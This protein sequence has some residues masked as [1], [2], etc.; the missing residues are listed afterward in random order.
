MAKRTKISTETLVKLGAPKLAALILDETAHNRRFKQFAQLALEAQDGPTS[1]ATALKRRFSTIARS[2]T[3]LAKEKKREQLSELNKLKSIA[4]NEIAEIDAKLALELLWEFL[5]LHQ[6]VLERIDDSSGRFGTM[7]R[8]A[9]LNLGPLAEAAKGDPDL[10][11][12][13]IF[14]KLMDN[15]YGIYD[16]LVAVLSEALGP[17]G[18]S[19]LRQA[20]LQHQNELTQ[21]EKH[22][23]SSHRYRDNELSAIKLALRE[24]ADCE[25]DPDAFIAT[26]DDSN[27]SNPRF[28]SEVAHRLLAAG[29]AEEALETLDA[30]PP[31]AGKSSFGETEWRDARIAVLDALDRAPEAQDLRLTAFKEQLSITHLREYLRRL[32]D[33]EDIEGEQTALD[34]V[35]SYPDV[36]RALAFYLNWPAQEHAGRLV[37]DRSKELDGDL[38]ELLGP[39]ANVLEGKWPLSAVLLQ[40][41]LIDVTLQ[42]GR[43]TRY[44]HAARHLLEI[45]SLDPLITDYRGFDTH[46]QFMKRLRALHPRKS[47]FWSLI[48]N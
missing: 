30:A 12:S 4:V 31:V 24:L 1:V 10:L 38:Y 21:D 23:R 11:A 26:F 28:A 20:L 44:K 35:S 42:K 6:S 3:F 37:V 32:P 27:L 41:A 46:E 19:K 17:E 7:F 25:G 36:H 5:D 8:D 16:E 18:R 33:F 47:G 29:R 2:G 40:R 14:R 39:A 13:T 34:F 43:S 48:D 22:P 9:C 15:G 45:D